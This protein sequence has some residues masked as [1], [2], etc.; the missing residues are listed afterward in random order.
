MIETVIFDLD[1]VII[2]SEPIHFSVEKELFREYDAD[3]SYEKHMSFVGNSSKNMWAEVKKLANTQYSVDELVSI[4]EEKYLQQLKKIKDIEPIPGVKELVDLIFNN[5]LNLAIASSSSR[6]IINT[7]IDKFNL[8][9][10]FSIVI[11]GAELKKS[12]PDPEIF[13]VASRLSN[14]DPKQ[15]LVIEDSGNGIKAAK[16]AGMKCIAFKN[17]NS[18]KQDLS[19]ADLV[20][21]DF[22]HFDFQKVIAELT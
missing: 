2:D 5:K 20:I 7:V 1:G 9:Q 8:S 16:L 6:N 14:T 3:I 21:D 4:N 22:N 11:S 13:N 19:L 10:Y 17:P 12:K 18:G 15:C